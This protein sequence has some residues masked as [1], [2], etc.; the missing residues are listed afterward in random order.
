MPKRTTSMV[1]LV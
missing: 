1:F